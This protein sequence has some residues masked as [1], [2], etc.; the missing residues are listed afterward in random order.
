MWRGAWGG[1]ASCHMH[2]TAGGPTARTDTTK[3]QAHPPACLPAGL[4]QPGACGRPHRRRWP[5]R[6]Q[7]SCRNRTPC[8]TEHL[9]SPT[10]NRVVGNGLAGRGRI[11]VAAPRALCVV[12]ATPLLHSRQ[13]GRQD[14]GGI[15]LGPG[16]RRWSGRGASAW[17]SWRPADGRS[18]DYAAM[19]APCSNYRLPLTRLLLPRPLLGVGRMQP[20]S[21]SGMV[22]DACPTNLMV[23][24]A[25]EQSA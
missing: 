7:P 2:P 21:A 22:L 15:H 20:H 25:E 6:W 10:V 18:K 19:Q 12:G 13:R 5:Y 3:A 17:H 4:V 1:Q 23:Q 9:P 14:V 8:A 16:S 11:Q 24:L